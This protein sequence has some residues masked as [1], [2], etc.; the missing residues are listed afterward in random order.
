[1]II[2]L[3]NIF[4]VVQGVSGPRAY[5]GVAYRGMAYP[6]IPYPGA[7]YPGWSYPGVVSPCNRW[8]SAYGYQGSNTASPGPTNSGPTYPGKPNLGETNPS[9]PW[10]PIFNAGQ[11]QKLIDISTQVDS[12]P[13]TKGQV[14]TINTLTTTTTTTTTLSTTE[15]PVTVTKDIK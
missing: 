2:H 12:Q 4:L 7:A 3:L 14:N 10:A 6:R 8:Q 11:A 1:M 5:P 13:N 15:A 9:Y